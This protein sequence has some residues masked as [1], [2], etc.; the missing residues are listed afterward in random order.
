M[1][2]ASY[3]VHKFREVSADCAKSQA[4]L[5]ERLAL[6]LQKLSPLQDSCFKPDALLKRWT[7]AIGELRTAAE[8]ERIRPQIACTDVEA[9][10]LIDEL[11]AILSGLE[12]WVAVDDYILHGRR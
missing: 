6:A 1:M 7:A 4:S 10:R 2:T 8:M 12:R 3:A 11:L 9:Q 5:H